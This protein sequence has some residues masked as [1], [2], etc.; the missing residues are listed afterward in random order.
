MS[1]P[2]RPQFGPLAPSR[3]ELDTE[4]LVRD[5]PKT[6]KPSLYSVLL[7][8]DDFTTMEYVIHVLMK[9]FAKDEAAAHDIMLKVHRS[10]RGLAGVYTYEIAETKVMMVTDDA[11]KNEYPLKVTMEKAE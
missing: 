5:R 7:H 6:K 11:R 8:N 2:D 9:Y 1:K 3:P 10:G 4:V